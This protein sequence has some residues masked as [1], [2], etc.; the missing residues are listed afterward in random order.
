[1]SR[2]TAALRSETGLLASSAAAVLDRRTIRLRDGRSFLS[3]TGRLLRFAA[4][5]AG[6]ARQLVE[7]GAAH[8]TPAPRPADD[9]TVVVPVRD[10]PRELARCLA[11]LG[12][13]DT[14]VVDDGSHDQEAVARVC[15]RYGARVVRRDNGGPA[16]ARNTAL[17][18]LSKEIVAFLDSDCVPPTGWLQQLRGHLDDPRVAA[19]APRVTGGLRS[20]LDLGGEPGVVRPGNPVAYVPTAA[21]LVRREALTPFDETLRFGEDVDLVWRMVEAGWLVRYDPRV[22]VH[23]EEPSRVGDRLVRRFRYGT[24]AAP[25][26]E[27][28]PGAV[29]HLVAP[30]WPT[31][32]VLA[33]MAGR[34]IAALAAAAVTGQRLERHLH[35]PAA[36]ARVTGRAVSGTAQGLGRAL[37]LLGPV[38]WLA[39]CRRPQLLALMAL[40][41]VVEQLER[42]PEAPALRY[43]GE[44][45]L[46]QAAYGA[47][48]VAGCVLHR[49]VR[50]LLPRV[51]GTG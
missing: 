51:R 1:M 45:L 15:A 2:S 35:D 14:L 8:P 33:L 5:P 50:P 32:A 21:L 38:A 25:L 43:V 24:S 10:R 29:T 34:P 40:P 16:A 44:G 46:E 49:T 19:V 17:P 23:H 20:P 6:I 30:P 41:L 27:R 9:V 37:S 22:V 4:P 13:V 36:S 47:G 7:A 26:S 3:P 31:A 39:G 12:D 48:V 11:A 28:H 18:L 42:R